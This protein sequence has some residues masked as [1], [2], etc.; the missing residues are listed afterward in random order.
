MT[1]KATPEETFGADTRCLAML[2]HLASRLPHLQDGPFKAGFETAIEEAGAY[3]DGLHA[4]GGDN[5]Q[6]L[7]EQMCD[8]VNGLYVLKE[9]KG[10]L[11]VV[12]NEPS[13]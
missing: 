6:T 3:L 10:P 12:V 8:L 11:G 4:D 5:A 7:L 1:T 9:A 2:L 13:I